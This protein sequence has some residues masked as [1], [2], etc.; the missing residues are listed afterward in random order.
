MLLHM[1][2]HLLQLLIVFAVVG[3]NIHWQW[4]PNGLLAGLA[5]GVVA[6][7]V[8][9]LIA[10]IVDLVRWLRRSRIGVGRRLDNYAGGRGSRLVGTGRHLDQPPQEP[11]RLG[12]RKHH[13]DLI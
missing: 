10:G 4:T 11:R 5:G 1:R 9:Y 12:V 13:G 7:V 8:T 2:W 3:T 6:F